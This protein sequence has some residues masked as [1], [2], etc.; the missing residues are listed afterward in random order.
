[1][2]LA[3]GTR[4]E[5]RGLQWA[6]LDAPNP[7]MRELARVALGRYSQEHLAKKYAV[8]SGRK[9]LGSDVKGHFESTHTKAKTI[10]RYM[11][12]LGVDAQ[13]LALA[14]GERLTADEFEMWLPR[15]RVKLMEVGHETGEHALIEKVLNE[16][17]ADSYERMVF[18]Q[19]LESFALAWYRERHGVPQA[20]SS[21]HAFGSLLAD[22]LFPLREILSHRAPQYQSA[23]VNIDWALREV[24]PISDRDTILNI[25]RGVLI[26]KG[27]DL[28]PFDSALSNARQ[29]AEEQRRLPGR[30]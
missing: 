9:T 8:V 26:A 7:R 21:I 10:A 12:I 16:F 19:A 23:L 13:H 2:E 15:L 25:V 17:T 20:C 5:L 28:Q 11:E 30:P 22:E 1:M 3:E 18:R 6:A 24:L 29:Y 14:A 4:P 27:R